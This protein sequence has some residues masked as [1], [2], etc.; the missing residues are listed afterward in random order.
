LSQPAG[1][2]TGETIAFY[3]EAAE[4]AA[5]R[6]ADRDAMRGHLDRFAAL[7]KSSSLVVDVGCGAGYDCR[8]LASRGVRVLGVD[9][10]L[11]P[12]R[13]G[14]ARYPEA[15]FAR[16]DIRLLGLR[17][18]CVDGIWAC[19]SLLH[20]PRRLM[21]AALGEVHRVLRPGGILFTSVQG[22][23]GEAVVQ[24]ETYGTSRTRLYVYYESGEWLGLLRE[25]GFD[26]FHSQLDYHEE[27]LDPGG[28]C[29]LVSF[30][31]RV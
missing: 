14:C 10:A 2:E 18:E 20:I 23:H 6:W 30:A 17:T 13:I 5:E 9:L 26:V 22:G 19:A 4:T 15:Q 16:Q 7:L 21:P 31:R 12:L 8:Q 29:W 1:E 25:D 28:K 27:S 3:E 24:D 11:A